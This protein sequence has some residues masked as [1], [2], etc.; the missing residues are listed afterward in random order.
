[1][2]T[3]DEV[4]RNRTV[5][6]AYELQTSRNMQSAAAIH[7]LESHFNAKIDQLKDVVEQSRTQIINVIRS[8]YPRP[9]KRNINDLEA[10]FRRD[11]EDL[12]TDMNYQVD[13]IKD[14]VLGHRPS[15]NQ[16]DYPRKQA[17]YGE[18]LRNSSAGMNSLMNWLKN[19]FSRLMDIVRGIAKQMMAVFRYIKDGLSYLYHIFF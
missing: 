9:H 19:L 5:V 17:Q 2:K 10:S 4:A 14:Q 3:F 1:M 7:E 16:P 18:L 13:K 11:V 15:P 6:D 12:K 8:K